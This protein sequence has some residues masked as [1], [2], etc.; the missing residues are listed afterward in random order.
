MSIQDVNEAYAL[1][2]FGLTSVTGDDTK[3]LIPYIYSL[4][5]SDLKLIKLL[6]YATNQ[7]ISTAIELS[8]SVY[9]DS[10][11]LIPI[12][13]FLNDSTGTYNIY[14][15]A[16]SNYR[17]EIQDQTFELRPTLDIYY[18]Y[19]ATSIGINIPTT[20]SD[21]NNPTIDLNFPTIFNDVSTYAFGCNIADDSE[22]YA[23]TVFSL[24]AIVLLLIIFVASIQS[25]PIQ[26]TI[27]SGI[28]VTLFTIIGFIPVWLFALTIIIIIAWGL[29]T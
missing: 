13:T 5:D 6:D 3:T 22:C 10:N 21:V 27:A 7:P 14:M 16:N 12:G 18:I 26:Q 17:L 19:L 4:G 15:D 25:T 9:T 11:G 2:T 20:T 8:L 24:I 1:T 29:F 23:P 28:L